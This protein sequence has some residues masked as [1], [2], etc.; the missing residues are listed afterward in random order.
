MGTKLLHKDE[1][2]REAKRVIENLHKKGKKLSKKK[3]EFLE[4]LILHVR[5]YDE[6]IESPRSPRRV[7]KKL[8]EARSMSRAAVVIA[9]NNKAHQPNLSA[10]LSAK[11]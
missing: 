11:R 7:L 3:M 1:E 10:I 4:M 2:Y 6:R 8:M 5:D 9:T